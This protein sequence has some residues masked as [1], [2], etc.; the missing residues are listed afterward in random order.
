MEQVTGIKEIAQ[1]CGVSASTVSRVLNG[2]S[3]V[4]EETRKRVMDAVK[5]SNFRPNLLARSLK[6]GDPKTI[7]MM[8]PMTPCSSK[9]S[10]YL[11]IRTASA[12]TMTTNKKGDLLCP[13]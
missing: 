11:R 8:I 10:P 5:Q 6:Q 2:K 1:R 4:R 9:M 13:H 7:C 3:C 12:A